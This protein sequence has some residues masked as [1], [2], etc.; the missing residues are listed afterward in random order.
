MLWFQAHFYKRHLKASK[1]E[2][3]K[4]KHVC[5]LNLKRLDLTVILTKQ[6]LTTWWNRN[7]DGFTNALILKRFRAYLMIWQKIEEISRQNAGKEWL[8][9]KMT[10]LWIG[11]FMTIY[12]H[13]FTN[14]I[15]NFHKTEELKGVL[16]YP[17]YENINWIKS[18]DINNNF[19]FVSIFSIL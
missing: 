13:F 6:W 1:N 15:N 8:K 12:C 5:C 19:C 3:K 17:I 10:K 16:V 11:Y 18:Y 4:E 9:M 14:Y 7:L 2:M